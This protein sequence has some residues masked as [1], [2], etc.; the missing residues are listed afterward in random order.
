MLL[1]KPCKAHPDESL[2]FNPL[3]AYFHARQRGQFKAVTVR[4]Q[5]VALALAFVRSFG[6]R[7]EK[8]RAITLISLINQGPQSK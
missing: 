3:L 7:L 2:M 4:V 6:S 5:Y 1:D 8:R